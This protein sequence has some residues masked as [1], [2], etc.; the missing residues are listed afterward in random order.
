M[1]FSTSAAAAII[2][3]GVFLSV[4]YIVGDVIPSMTD[5]H[6]SLEAMRDRAVDQMQSDINITNV[7]NTSS[8]S[9]YN[10]SVSVRNTGS[11]TLEISYFNVLINGSIQDFNC[12][13]SYIYPEKTEKIYLYNQAKSGRIKIV[14]D[15]GI[16]DYYEYNV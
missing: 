11:T 16:S 5:T 8:G 12:T 6:D 7:V 10:L 3:V 13:S 4:Q 14:T 1:G 15:N 2:G 9:L